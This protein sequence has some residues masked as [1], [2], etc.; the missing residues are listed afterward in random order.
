[1]AIINIRIIQKFPSQQNN[2]KSKNIIDEKQIKFDSRCWF[3]SP[4]LNLVFLKGVS[5]SSSFLLQKAK[6][7]L[8]TFQEISDSGQRH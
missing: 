7:F 4:D 5:I 1:L 6:H 8:I 3:R 2:F